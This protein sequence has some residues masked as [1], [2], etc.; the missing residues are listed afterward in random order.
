MTPLAEMPPGWTAHDV[1]VAIRELWVDPG[2]YVVLGAAV[3]AL[4]WRWL[5]TRSRK[6][7]A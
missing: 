1:T 6:P 2:W 5:G 4:L 7:T 3:V